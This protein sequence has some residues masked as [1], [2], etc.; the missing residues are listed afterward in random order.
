MGVVYSATH[1]RL[2]KQVAIKVLNAEL[3]A[4][5]EELLR[6]NREAE[7]T[8]G[9]GHPHV[10]QVFDVGT[11]AVGAPFLV[12]EFL[13]GEGLET[14]LHR[15]GCLSLTRTVRLVKQIAS[16]L[17]ATHA[18]QIVHRDLKP[19]NIFLVSASADGDFAKVLDFGISKVRSATTKLTRAQ[20]V[21]GTP[22]YMSPEQARGEIE[23]IDEATDQWALACIAWECLSGKPPFLGDNMMAILFQI[24]HQEPKPLKG[25][26]L[27]PEVEEVLRRA[28]S[29][30]KAGRFPS[31][32][33]FATA[34]EAAAAGKPWFA[35]DARSTR[36]TA[37]LTVQPPDPA[38]HVPAPTMVAPAPANPATRLLSTFRSTAGEVWN[39]SATAPIPRPKKWLWPTV[40]GAALAVAAVG[41][42]A[43]R[44]QPVRVAP[45]G[46]GPVQPT[47]ATPAP[48]AAPVPA[49]EPAPAAAPVPAPT[50]AAT[51]PIPQPVAVPP[52]PAGADQAPKPVAHEPSAEKPS[53]PSPKPAVGHRKTIRPSSKSPA[54]TERKLIEDL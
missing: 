18:K 28:L 39:E 36:R 54:R 34:F 2:G 32:G 14:W 30:D 7:V 48:A 47:V 24:V 11:T 29:K 12:M 6:F 10:V 20:A 46:P 33:E 42:F 38:E 15:E 25:E 9:L 17:T 21:M 50:P 26:G 3:A 23:D 53:E 22:D 13:R 31:V 43:L 19:A 37:P 52:A 8:S 49:P 41:F 16:A 27:S 35:G 5:E 45:A 1:L 44:S 4:N 40:G 51:A